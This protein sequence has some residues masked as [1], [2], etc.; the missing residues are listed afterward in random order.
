MFNTTYSIL[1][2]LLELHLAEQVFRYTCS[3]KN[4]IILYSTAVTAPVVQ[5]IEY[6]F[7]EP[8]I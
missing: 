5:W 1:L 7:A 6:R 2:M 4:S 8:E 3:G